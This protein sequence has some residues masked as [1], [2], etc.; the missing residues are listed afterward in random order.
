MAHL[1]G[2]PSQTKRKKSKRGT[3]IRP[4]LF[5]LL[6]VIVIAMQY[7]HPEHY[8]DQ[9]LLRQFGTSHGILL[10]VLY[11]GAWAVGPFFLPGLP[12]TLAGGVLF[13]PFWGVIYVS[14]GSA[15]GAALVFLVSRY[16]ARDWVAHRLAGTRLRT[17][18]DKV[19]RHGWK[20]VAF[21]RL[22][23]VFSYSLLNYAFGLTR[24]GFWPYLA[25]T[26]VCMVPATIAFVYFSS[27]ILDL[28]HG[29]ISWQLILGVILVVLVSL[30]PLIYKRLKARSRISEDF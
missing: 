15:L 12:L 8:L 3:L 28:L 19:A 27:N 14:F 13:G 6:I 18:D 16:L 22:V 24:V 30:I 17:L 5:M 1:G 29:K 10:P 11:L 2:A 26:F 9:E 7:V 23:P 21:T 20:I 25:A 4:L